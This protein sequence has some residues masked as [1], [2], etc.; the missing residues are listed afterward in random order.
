MLPRLLILDDLFGR[1]SADGPN[2]DRENL[3][4]HFL[5]QDATADSSAKASKQKVLQPTADAVFCR[6]QSPASSKPGDTVENDL[7]MALEAVRKGWPE[8]GLKRR[9]RPPKSPPPRWS[10]VLIDLC[11]YTGRVTEESHRRTPGMPEG[12]PG[13]DD[14]RSY[15]GL[16]LLDSIHR[17]FPEL[18]VFILSS[19]PRGEVSLEFSRRGALG[20]IDRSALDSPEQLEQALWNHGLLADPSGEVVGRALPIL[21]A[22]R[23]ARRAAGHRQHVLIRGERGSGKER[24]ARY[25]HR[26]ASERARAP[27]NEWVALNA[28]GLTSGAY[29]A[30]L[31]GVQGRG[32]EQRPGLLVQSS[33]GTL[34]LDEVGDVPPK[35][36][37]ALLQVLDERA[38]LPVGAAQSLPL[39]LRVVAA[40]DSHGSPGEAAPVRPDLLDRLSAGGV[41]E[42]PPLMQRREDLPKLAEAFLVEAADLRPGMRARRITDEAMER[43][44]THDWPGNVRELRSVI[45]D[46]VIRFPDVEYLV[47]E[48]LGIGKH[49]S[50]AIGT[51]R[52]VWTNKN[53]GSGPGGNLASVSDLLAELQAVSFDPLRPREWA[54]ILPEMRAA[55]NRMLSRLLMAA[56]IATKHHGPAHPE[57]TLRIQSAARLL[58]GDPHLT[59]AKAADLFKRLLGPL[60]DELEGELVE[61]YRIALRLRPKSAKSK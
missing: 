48:H 2:V 58:T 21:L 32:G 41:L 33:G 20:F 55:Q 14:P 39:D 19:K 42:M 36:Q 44:Q 50:F 49:N 28:A 17:E 18:P 61:A 37:A 34:F 38:V 46:A 16:T 43:L 30:E 35:V 4:A 7:E 12:R 11:F 6:A 26:C 1:C 22:L 45:F 27:T 15:F 25:L 23:E 47:P 31:F 9:G 5:W 60:A 8:A 56:L 57:G 29:P 51:R 13:D 54:G 10:M 24:L 40:M 3:C 53:P 52:V 59:G